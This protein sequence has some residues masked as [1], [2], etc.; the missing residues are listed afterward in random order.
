MM[1]EGTL[2]VVLVWSAKCWIRRHKDGPE[3]KLAGPM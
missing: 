2:K 3:P 1:L